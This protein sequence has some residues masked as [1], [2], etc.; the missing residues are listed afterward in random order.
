MI[1]ADAVA[2]SDGAALRLVEE[3][4]LRD[5]VDVG[6]V[7]PA[8]TG[9]QTHVQIAVAVGD[10]TAESLGEG[11]GE[12]V[13]LVDLDLAVDGGDADAVGFLVA[14]QTDRRVGS[15]QVVGVADAGVGHAN[16]HGRSTPGGD[17]VDALVVAIETNHLAAE[18]EG[19]AGVLDEEVAERARAQHGIR[20]VDRAA[21][22][23]AEQDDLVAVLQRLRAVELLVEPGELKASTTFL[24]DV[25]QDGRAAEGCRR[26]EL[27]DHATAASATKYQAGC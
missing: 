4:H 17:G 6:G 12:L 25:E 22:G 20:Q 26:A 1:L 13:S 7:L 2:V 10:G 19:V 11:I 14:G 16:P 8:D 21:S 24:A 27:D 5:G 9:E 15:K 18:G 3:L 23:V